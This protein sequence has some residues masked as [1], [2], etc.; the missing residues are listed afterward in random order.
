M[1]PQLVAAQSR[2]TPSK[3]V[4]LEEECI[5]EQAEW[6]MIEKDTNQMACKGR[7]YGDEQEETREQRELTQEGEHIPFGHHPLS[8]LGISPQ[9]SPPILDLNWMYTMAVGQCTSPT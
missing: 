9:P 4:A 7:E 3:L 1:H 6:L 2:L 8:L 5:H